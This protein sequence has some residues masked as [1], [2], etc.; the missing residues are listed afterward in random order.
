[1]AQLKNC[2]ACGEVFAAVS[3]DICPPCYFIEEQK[4]QYVYQFLMKRKNR[5][6]NIEEIV[7]ATEVE[8]NLVV[9]FL[10]DNRL[11]VT[12]FPN[13]SYACDKCGTSITAGKLCQSCKKT[14]QNKWLPQT[15]DANQESE[16]K[17][18]AFHVSEIEKNN[19][20]KN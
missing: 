12:N 17:K 19:R 4:F 10:K 9:K 5:Q 16:S 20:L 14:I 11:R 13:L 18:H 3:R 7:E 6:A 15:D 1:M 2:S 8:E